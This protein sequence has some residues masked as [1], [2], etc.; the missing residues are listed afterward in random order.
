MKNN[1]SSLSN[2][3]I[4]SRH[5]QQKIDGYQ[6]IKVRPGDALSLVCSDDYNWYIISGFYYKEQL[7]MV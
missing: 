7:G 4:Q 5:P 3:I 2:V 6:N 1:V